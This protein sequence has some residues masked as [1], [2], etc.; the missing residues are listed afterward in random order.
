MNKVK[1]H[2][3]I[4]DKFS[5]DLFSLVEEDFFAVRTGDEDIQYA[6]HSNI[7]SITV[8]DR[9]T[10]FGWRDVESG[11]RDTNGNFW[12]ASGRC[13]VME[14]GASTIGEAIKWIKDRA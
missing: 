2:T 7:G 4:S 10:G 14:S 6:F 13:N 8:V 9:L 5:A 11:F 12:L 1:T 3:D